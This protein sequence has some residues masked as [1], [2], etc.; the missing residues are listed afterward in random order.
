VPDLEFR[1]LVHSDPDKQQAT[2][3]PGQAS[4][5]NKLPRPD[6]QTRP[7]SRVKDDVELSYRPGV[8]GVEPK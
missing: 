2:L 3:Q 1:F 6:S 7:G 5:Y 8:A 4:S